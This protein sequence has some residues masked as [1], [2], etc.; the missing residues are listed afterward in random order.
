M[1]H[2]ICSTTLICALNNLAFRWAPVKEPCPQCHPWECRLEYL[3]AVVI[4]RSFHSRWTSPR[5]RLLKVMS[6]NKPVVCATL[7]PVR[8]SHSCSCVLAQLRHG[9]AG[10]AKAWVKSCFEPAG[11]GVLD[12]THHSEDHKCKKDLLIGR[13]KHVENPTWKLIRPRPTKNQYMGLYYI[14]KGKLSV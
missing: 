7:K 2:K 14:C 9:F 3:R 12:Y 13:I 4:R 5:I 8:G 10:H 1:H 11:P 6:L